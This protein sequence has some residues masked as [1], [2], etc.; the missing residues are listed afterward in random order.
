MSVVNS[1][2]C[3]PSLDLMYSALSSS[4]SRCEELQLEWLAVDTFWKVERMS[5]KPLVSLAYSCCSRMMISSLISV[6]MV[7][8]DC[9][10]EL[11]TKVHPKGRNHG[12]GPY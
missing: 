12:E 1:R 8:A 9:G 6:A 2:C 4:P 10:V 11:E 3:S 5:Q 7:E